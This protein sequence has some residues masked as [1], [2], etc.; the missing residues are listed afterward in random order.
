MQSEDKE[1]AM[2]DGARMNSQT[3]PQAQSEGKQDDRSVV[4]AAISGE[5]VGSVAWASSMGGAEPGQ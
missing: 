5:S 3:N 2:T 4:V 1:D